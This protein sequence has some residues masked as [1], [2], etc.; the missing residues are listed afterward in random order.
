MVIMVF[1]LGVV[2]IN[3]HRSLFTLGEIPTTHS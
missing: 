1:V 3:S 2:K